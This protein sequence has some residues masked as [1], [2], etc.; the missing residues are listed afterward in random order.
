M[1]PTK[2]GHATCTAYLHRPD[3]SGSIDS[4]WPGEIASVPVT[5]ARCSLPVILQVARQSLQ[6]EPYLWLSLASHSTARTEDRVPA[7][8]ETLGIVTAALSPFQALLAFLP[9]HV[10]F[11]TG[12]EE[13]IRAPSGSYPF[14]PDVS[15][16]SL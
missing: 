16:V 6:L 10:V 13:E 15:L 8:V 7:P 4:S 9:L 14:V 3:T 5:R 2:A 11:R 1:P 12:K